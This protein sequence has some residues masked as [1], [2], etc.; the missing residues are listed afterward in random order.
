MVNLFS[1][2]AYFIFT[3]AGM[4]LIKLGGQA[5]YQ[6][7][8]TVPIIDFRVSLTSLAGFLLYG[9][10][11]VLYSSLLVKYELS[12]LNPFTIGITSI[13]IFASG[14][15]FFNETIT[16]VKLISLGLILSGVLLINIVK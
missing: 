12:F 11:F 4:V 3:C 8:L 10:S 16:V 14:A 13:L 15:L 1:F 6:S 2:I 9:M 7:F 5:N